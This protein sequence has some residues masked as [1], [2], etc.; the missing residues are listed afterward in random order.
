MKIKKILF[1]QKQPLPYS[2]ILSLT[3]M[4]E[5]NGY[6]VDVMI[7]SL[8]NRFIHT[9]REISPD[10]IGITAMSMER[11]WIEKTGMTIKSMLPTI[12]IVVGGVHAILY[13]ED[14]IKIKSVDYVC[15]SEGEITL[16]NLIKFIEN[17][18]WDGRSLKGIWLRDKKGDVI[19][20]EA[21][22]I[23][24]DISQYIENRKI[25]YRRYPLMEKDATKFFIGSRGCPYK[26]SYCFNKQMR[27][28]FKGR[29]Q[30][31]RFKKPERFIEEI[32]NEKTRGFLKYVCFSDDLFIMNKKWLEE[33]TRLYKAHIRIPFMCQI[34]PEFI[35]E[36]VLANLKESGCDKVVF[37]IETGNEDLRTK[38]L[39]KRIKNDEFIKMAQL[40]KKY[41][42]KIHTFNMF[43]IPT[44]TLENSFETIMLNVKI[45]AD[46]VASS[47][48]MP[49]PGTELTDLAIKAGCLASTYSF[50]DI[51]QSFHRKSILK[52]PVI[53]KQEKI[54]K[55]IFIACKYPILIPFIKR[56]IQ[57]DN[58]FIK[59]VI[60]PMFLF[61]F[62]LSYLFRFK[63]GRNS[64]F[65]I[66][67]F[68]YR[69]RHSY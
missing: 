51:P 50:N 13:P 10:L 44:E 48:F 61:L 26:C 30:L 33:F 16:L 21:G 3:S 6:E 24:D 46:I 54:H 27:E 52:T 65:G 4:L 69:F 56:I 1:I 15:N 28:I 12:P 67:R 38:I 2:G 35:N 40:V 42:M 8:E 55:I 19:Q 49:F 62:L 31:I 68:I 11:N 17:D 34:R 29:G 39:N 36:D 45:K 25:Y 41:R 22:N 9:I 14:V 53:D 23:N 63:G 20:N 57:T 5:A 47:M 60:S 37:G 18:G 7:S 64:F 66:L 59:H 58:I 32:E 43:G